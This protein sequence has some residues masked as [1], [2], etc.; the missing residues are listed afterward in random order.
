MNRRRVKR[1]ATKK[2][3]ENVQTLKKW[4]DMELRRENDLN[5]V[6]EKA[7][8]ELKYYLKKLKKTRLRDDRIRYIRM[9]TEDQGMFYRKTQGMREKK[10]NALHIAKL[11]NMKNSGREFGMMIQRN[12]IGNG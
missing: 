7:L 9:L 1:K 8:D 2:E 5:Y 3:K 6:K 12:L 4:T 10:G 11:L